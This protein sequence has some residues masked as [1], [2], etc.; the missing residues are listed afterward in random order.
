MSGRGDGSYNNRNG[1][2]VNPENLPS[3]DQEPAYEPH[4]GRLGL[5][6]SLFLALYNTFWRMNEILDVLYASDDDLGIDFDNVNDGNV[7]NVNIPNINVRDNNANELHDDQNAVIVGIENE[8]SDEAFEDCEDVHQ[9]IPEEDPQP[10]VSRRRSREMDEED[11]EPSK[12]SDGA[13]SF[14]MTTLTSSLLVTL[15]ARAVLM[16]VILLMRTSKN[17]CLVDPQKDPERKM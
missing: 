12:E 13:R 14:L 9:Y 5:L 11:V 2:Q 16:L 4:G 10:G 17:R 6:N 3:G 15:I 8:D 1:Q 7:N